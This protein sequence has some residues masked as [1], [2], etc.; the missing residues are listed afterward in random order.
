MPEPTILAAAPFP[1][2]LRNFVATGLAGELTR[3]HH[4]AV[5]FITPYPQAQFVDAEGFCYPNLSVRSEPGPNGVPTVG[6]VTL[7][8]RALK[9]VHLTGFALEYPDGRLQNLELSRR[10]PPQPLAAVALTT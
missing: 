10:R 7:L 3:R 1:L 9:S 4:A 5:H 8:D 2:T 6:G